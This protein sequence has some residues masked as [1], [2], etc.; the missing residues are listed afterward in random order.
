MNAYLSGVG[1]SG[2]ENNGQLNNMVEEVVER[3]SK[4]A[5]FH[6]ADGRILAEY[7]KYY[8]KN[9][10][11]TV[12][13][14]LDDVGDFH[15]EYSFP[16][17]RSEVLSLKNNLSIEPQTSR[18]AYSAA[19]DDSRIG[20]TIIF[21]LSNMGDVLRSMEMGTFRDE[22][23]KV[24]LS[25][26]AMEGKILLPV[27]EK[28]ECEKFRRKAASNRR[29]LL[30]AAREGDQEAIES[31]TVE[32]MDTYSAISE[33]LETEDILTIVES[34]LMPCGVECDQ[35]RILGTIRQCEKTQNYVT[36]E[37]LFQMLIECNDI[38]IS[39]CANSEDLL[40]EP[41]KGRRFMGRIWLQGEVLI[42]QKV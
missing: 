15:A 33:R 37:V 29:K 11:M 35:Y 14:E 34:T 36:G 1:F 16:F 2:I 32:D 41:L 4:K 40:G 38:L 12:I 13:G 21:Y 5:V 24:R 26:I 18:D 42:N 23:K 8:A 6:S 20:I 3:Y 7:S 9:C 25:G 30:H 19:C 22:K 28:K 17:Y 39:I 10:G 27:Y 31:L